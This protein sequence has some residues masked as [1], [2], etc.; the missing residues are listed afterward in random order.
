MKIRHHI[1]NREH[2]VGPILTTKGKSGPNPTINM[3][4]CIGKGEKGETKAKANTWGRGK[5]GL[6][7]HKRGQIDP[8]KGQTPMKK[9]EEKNTRNWEVERSIPTPSA[10]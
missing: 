10:P 6:R 2:H 5:M 3:S 9:K 7:Q 4:D 8:N 1:W